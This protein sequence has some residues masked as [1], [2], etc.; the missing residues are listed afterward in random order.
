MQHM[1]TY[2]EIMMVSSLGNFYISDD[3]QVS[4][5]NLFF[6]V[7][8]NTMWLNACSHLGIFMCMCDWYVYW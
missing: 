1:Q 7:Y 3:F 8:S 6:S 2:I 5:N 4:F